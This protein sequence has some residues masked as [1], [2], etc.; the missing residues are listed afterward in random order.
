MRVSDRA[1][2]LARPSGKKIAS[3]NRPAV[4]FSITSAYI[5]T[6]LSVW[7]FDAKADLTCYWYPRNP[8]R[9]P[10]K[11]KCQ[12]AKFNASEMRK[13]VRVWNFY[14]S[15]ALLS[16]IKETRILSSRPRG[17]PA[18]I[19]QN[20]PRDSFSAATQRDRNTLEQLEL[21][22][23]WITRDY[24]FP[25]Y[26]HFA[27]FRG[28]TREHVAARGSALLIEY[29]NPRKLHKEKV[30]QS[31]GGEVRELSARM[32][33]AIAESHRRLRTRRMLCTTNGESTYKILQS[34]VY[35]NSTPD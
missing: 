28:T 33:S 15:P 2:S 26:L 10:G 20:S 7:H 32:T 18:R 14:L 19:R 8:R 35:E 11:G 25:F 23:T 31:R 4:Y 30:S 3:L 12:Y 27:A 24:V 1:R 13:C 9:P 29:P 34:V 16:K 17:C 22:L 21:K 6:A 5:V